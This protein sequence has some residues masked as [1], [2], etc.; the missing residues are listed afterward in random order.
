[1]GATALVVVLMRVGTVVTD[2]VSSLLLRLLLWC[3]V[4]VVL[5]PSVFVPSDTAGKL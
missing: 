1:M 4:V 3:S 2:V 5:S